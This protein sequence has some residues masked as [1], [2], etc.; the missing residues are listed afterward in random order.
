MADLHRSYLAATDESHSLFDHV[1]LYRGKP[2]LN[3]REVLD[4]GYGSNV[5]DRP[6]FTLKEPSF[7]RLSEVVTQMQLTMEMVAAVI[8]DNEPMF[9]IDPEKLMMPILHAT[10]SH[11]RLERAWNVI[12]T[13]LSRAHDKFT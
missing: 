10:N 3:K 8:G 13:R 7:N 1:N 12:V 4:R 6:R 11:F 5:P 2:T 9:I